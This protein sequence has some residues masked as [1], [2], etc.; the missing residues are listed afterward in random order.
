MC[1]FFFFFFFKFPGYIIDKMIVMK[2]LLIFI[3]LFIKLFYVQ[4]KLPQR[5][6]SSDIGILV[7]NDFPLFPVLHVLSIYM[8]I[9]CTQF[10]VSNNF[11]FN[12]S[13]PWHMPDLNQMSGLKSINWEYFKSKF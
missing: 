1:P 7:S 10:V 11:M 3:V 4:N 9:L 5:M 13:L 6:H 8:Y 2:V 12:H